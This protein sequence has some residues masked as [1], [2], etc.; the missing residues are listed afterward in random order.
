M[1]LQFNPS[2]ISKFYRHIFLHC[3]VRLIFSMD[4]SRDIECIPYTISKLVAVK[5]LHLLHFLKKKSSTCRLRFLSIFYSHIHIQLIHLPPTYSWPQSKKLIEFRH[6][7][8]ERGETLSGQPGVCLAEWQDTCWAVGTKRECARP[9]AP[10]GRS[11][12]L[13]ESMGHQVLTS[14]IEVRGLRRYGT[15]SVNLRY[16][17]EGPEK[18]WGTKC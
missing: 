12:G 3:V 11:V 1:N 15:P 9:E 13:S 8:T 5:S 17:S 4:I 6:F 7:C 18:V 10:S 2:P 16:R 14:G